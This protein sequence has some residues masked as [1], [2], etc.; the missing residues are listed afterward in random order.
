MTVRLTVNLKLREYQERILEKALSL[1]NVVVVLPQGTGKSVIGLNLIARGGFNKAIILVHRKNLM[2]S[3]IERAN[4][5]MPGTLHVVD[6]SLDAEKRTEIYRSKAIVLTT[7]QL[8]RNDLRRCLTFLSD[9]DLIVID[10]FAE[11]VAKF[12]GGYRRNVFYDTISKASHA[13]IVGLMPPFM[14]DSRLSNIVKTFNASIISVPFSAVKDF[15]PQYDTDVIEIEDPF[16]SK[17]D[18]VVG[19]K[20]KRLHGIVFKACKEHGLRVTREGVYSLKK[21]ELEALDENAQ[22][23]FWKMRNVLDFRQKLL[24]GNKLKLRDS[25]LCKHPEAKEWIDS[26]DRKSHKLVEILKN[27]QKERAIIFCG[28][29][30]IL[31]HLRSE[32]EKAGISSVAVTGDVLDR[33]ERKRI[34]DKFRFGDSH[35]LLATDVIDAGV[36]IPQGDFV[37]HYTFSWDSYRHRQKNERIRGG[38]QIFIVYK[39]SSEVS[40]VKSLLNEVKR[41]QSKYVIGDQ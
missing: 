33:E 31:Y 10:E 16:I 40:K 4:E 11:V 1:K 23:S 26:I 20:I 39:N 22:R 9:F 37:I 38:Q 19:K 27:R 24:Y 28:F 25:R 12:S 34:M 8:F 29:K 30:E 7:I 32:L 3:W 5:W 17:V 6:A 15:I 18:K 41:I 2:N 14:R 36:D 21:N 35:V 13:K